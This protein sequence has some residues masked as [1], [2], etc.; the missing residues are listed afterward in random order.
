MQLRFG[1]NPE[2]IF[3]QEDCL[4]WTTAVLDVFSVLS[5]LF[6]SNKFT[7]TSFKLK[8]QFK[9]GLWHQKWFGSQYWLEVRWVG[10]RPRREWGRFL[11]PGCIDGTL[12]C[13]PPPL[14]LCFHV[15]KPLFTCLRLSHQQKHSHTCSMKFHELCSSASLLY[16]TF[17]ILSLSSHR[18]QPPK[19]KKKVL[20]IWS[21]SIAWNSSGTFTPPCCTLNELFLLR[22]PGSDLV[23]RLH[24]QYDITSPA[25]QTFN[26]QFEK[27][28][29]QTESR[30]YVVRMSL[31]LVAVLACYQH[32]LTIYFC[33]F[34]VC[35]SC[36]CETAKFTVGWS[37]VVPL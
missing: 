2:S 8:I 29:S 20:Q 10:L 17:I 9:S 19:V 27:R 24:T 34:R 6:F 33:V 36:L 23:W 12:T 25:A 21:K 35:F 26:P 30:I 22:R 31:Y 7:W 11:W 28:R 32:I 16:F 14:A 3:T 13:P 18:Q 37:K 15:V 1:Q 4:A 5:H